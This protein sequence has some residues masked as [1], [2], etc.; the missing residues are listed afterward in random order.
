MGARSTENS[1]KLKNLFGCFF[2]CVE[3]VQA[4]KL[5][6]LIYASTALERRL[7]GYNWSGYAIPGLRLHLGKLGKKRW[8]FAA[9]AGS[10][11][12]NI[13][14]QDCAERACDERSESD[15]C[16]R[17]RMRFS[18]RSESIRV[19]LWSTHSSARRTTIGLD[20]AE[21]NWNGHTARNAV[22][23]NREESYRYMASQIC[24]GARRSIARN[25][26]H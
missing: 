6:R 20:H 10:R 18:R 7:T 24:A 15:P 3:S 16:A 17:L 26:G 11:A 13:K 21:L 1:V 5:V 25:S 22:L 2:Q 19:G 8:F 9:D 14:M 4:E 12:G 23:R